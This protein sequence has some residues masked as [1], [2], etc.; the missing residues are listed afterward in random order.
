MGCGAS[1]PAEKAA[2][3][4]PET[5]KPADPAGA[6]AAEPAKEEK[7]S[8]VAAVTDAVTDA[9]E[10][11][12]DGVKHAAAAVM[13]TFASK[14]T[15]EEEGLCKA[16]KAAEEK[17]AAGDKPEAVPLNKRAPPEYA[18]YNGLCVNVNTG[19]AAPDFSLSAVGGSEKVSLSGLLADKPVLMEFISVT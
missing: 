6:P 2:D 1:L 4:A 14:T 8:I 9:V 15:E 3:K 16:C 13:G 19:D 5:D 18:G 11:A 10:D 12:V 7:K 17:E